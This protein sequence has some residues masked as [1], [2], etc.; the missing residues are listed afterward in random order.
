MVVFTP[1]NGIRYSFIDTNGDGRLE[2]DPG[3]GGIQPVYYTIY[4]WN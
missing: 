3:E 1:T 2:G 4:E